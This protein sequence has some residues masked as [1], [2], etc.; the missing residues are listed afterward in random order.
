MNGI[1]FINMLAQT[2]GSR[3]LRESLYAYPLVSLLHVLSLGLFTGGIFLVDLRLTGFIFRGLPYAYVLERTL[4]WTKLGFWLTSFSG[5]LLF[6]A[7]PDR[8]FHSVWFRAKILLIV[9]GGVNAYY[10]HA[11]LT[12][13]QREDLSVP[14]AFRRTGIL[15]LTIWIFT[16]LAG[17]LIAYD[18]FDCGHEIP[19]WIGILSQCAESAP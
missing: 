5:L 3:A 18:W 11:R 4:P 7:V 19:K 10:F 8:N 17:R 14:T 13:A 16:V 1:E 15:S 6:Y 2:A 9:F 12:E